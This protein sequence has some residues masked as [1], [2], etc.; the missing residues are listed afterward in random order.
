MSALDLTPI[1]QPIFETAGLVVAGLL[2][3]HV[4]KAI[5]A[6]QARTGIMLTDQQRATILGSVQ[7]GAGILETELDKGALTV[8]HINISNPT[9]L[10]QAQA[11]VNAVPVAAASLGITMNDAARMIV[12]AVD[13]AAHP[14][15]AA[16]PTS[17]PA[18]PS[19][20]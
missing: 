3:A 18:A 4:P 11:A 5:A 15:A 1:V 6:F 20:A 9:V 7:T 17:A 14:G 8:A 10:A 16:S 19:A 12:G 13:T 2:T